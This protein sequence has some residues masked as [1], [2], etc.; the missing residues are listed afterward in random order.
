MKMADSVRPYCEQCRVAAET[1][2]GTDASP[3]TM[4]LPAAQFLMT[5][6]VLLCDVAPLIRCSYF[7][8][9]CRTLNLA[10]CDARG[11]FR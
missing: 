11:A 2:T 1:R 10:S 9:G 5:P 3:P 8:D 6:N 4:Y 7:A